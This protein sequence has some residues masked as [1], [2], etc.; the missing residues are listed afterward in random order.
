[1]R[2]VCWFCDRK[3]DEINNRLNTLI[4]GSRV[5][6]LR[7]FG[8][9]VL[10]LALAGCAMIKRDHYDVPV[11]SLPAQFKNAPVADP[12][13]SDLKATPAK[14]E[15]KLDPVL[16]E[17]WHA[18]GSPELDD[19]INRGLANN[20]DVRIATFRIVQA[21]ARAGQADAGKGPT[22]STPL[23]VTEQFPYYGV[24][25]NPIQN[26]V[27]V[28][29]PNGEK[30]QQLFQ[31]SIRGDWRVDLWGELDSLAQSANLQ[32]WRA[33]FERDN[34]QGN[35]AANIATS[36]I[37]YLSLNDRI[38]VAR[39]TE[40]VLTGMMAAVEDRL[41]V[42]DATAIDLEQERTA[43]YQVRATIPALEQQR[44]DALGTIAFLLGTVPESLKLSDNGLDSLALPSVI[45]GVP[46]T[47]LLRRPDVRMVEARLLAADADIDVARAR[48]LPPLDLSAQVGYGSYYLSQLFKPQ[49]L[50]W[51]AMGNLSATIFDGGKLSKEKDY[52][53]AVHEEMV[54]TYVRTIYQAVREVDS[55]L[56]AI[57]QTGKRLDAQ[58]I[59]ADAAHRAW[60]F[61]SEVYAAG[62]IDYL[63]LVDSERTYHR[64]LDEYHRIRTE[65]YQALV[66]LFHALGGGVPQGE[67]LPGKGVRPTLPPGSKEGVVLAAPNNVLAVEGVDWEINS[68]YDK[69]NVWLVELPGLYHRKTIDA[70]WLDLRTRFPALTENHSLRRYQRGRMEDSANKRLSWY[71]LYIAKFQTAADAEELCAALQAGHQRCRVV[72]SQKGDIVETAHSTLHMDSTLATPALTVS[73]LVESSPVLPPKI[74]SVKTSQPGQNTDTSAHQLTLAKD[75]PLPVA[76]MKEELVS[77]VS[78]DPKTAPPVVQASVTPGAAIKPGEESKVVSSTGSPAAKVAVVETPA[79]AAPQAEVPHAEVAAIAPAAEVAAAKVAVV[80]TP[81]VAVPQAEV[82]RA[83]VAAIAPAAEVPAAKVAVVE[84][85]PVA[86]PQA[87]VP[88]AEVAAIAPVAEVAAAKVA[89]AETPPVAV[90]QAEAPRAEVAAIAPPRAKVV[91]AKVAVV[92]TPAAVVLQTEVPHAEV[93]TIAPAATVSAAEAPSADNKDLPNTEPEQEKAVA[94]QVYVV[95]LGT[96]R[97]ASKAMREASSWQAK[98]YEAYVRQYTRGNGRKWYK[99]LSG[100]FSRYGEAEAMAVAIDQKEGIRAEVVLVPTDENGKPEKIIDAHPLTGGK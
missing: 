7:Y 46:S 61:N 56:N 2:S 48:I 92:E 69:E 63:V 85:P 75:I 22:I 51:N 27:P 54:E 33:S 25:G 35:V 95:Q 36:Y 24:T 18:F 13:S 6:R 41:E 9:S 29:G 86:A 87:E 31:A 66:N 50:F 15:T 57:H 39:E 91:A 81:P 88:R 60:D 77:N 59:S 4:S 43:V 90:P 3:R 58:K 1:M 99:I 12:A 38:R 100:S 78:S 72:L 73:P 67:A 26:V 8:L 20:P 19:L 21:K 76:P 96:Y 47:L 93:A 68:S 28:T 49:S 40:T 42:G 44:E 37:E 82:P 55:A 65:R 53:Q 17:W 98:G 14:P 83:E 80:E 71:Q 30:V 16:V 79:V 10:T 94:Q 64:N 74:D 89:V 34:T 62:A 23:S 5:P 45:P 70:A 97:Y 84:T 52:A 32:L 11:V